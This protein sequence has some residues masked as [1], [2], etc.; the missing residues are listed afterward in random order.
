MVETQQP[1]AIAH[2]KGMGVTGIRISCTAYD[3]RR[4]NTLAFDALP[5]PDELAFPK[6]EASGRL[7]CRQ[8]G[9]RLVSVMPDWSGYKAQGGG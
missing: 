3:C 6:I 1:P 9:S 2:F 5:F 7:V 4:N 8:C